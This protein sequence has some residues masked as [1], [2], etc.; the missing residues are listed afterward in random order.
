MNDR[1]D[2]WRARL[3]EY[4]DG[5]LASPE[6]A[7]LEEHLEECGDCR[8]LLDDLRRVITQ[9][10]RLVDSPPSEDLWAGIAERIHAEKPA[11]I[12]RGASTVTDRHRSR[13][14]SRKLSF[15]M[16]QLAAAAVLLVT[17]SSGVAWQ[18]AGGFSSRQ[19]E[20]AGPAPTAVASELLRVARVANLDYE[21]AIAQLETAL[22]AGR[23]SLDTATVR[24]VAER[25]A[26]IDRAIEEARQALAADPSNAYLNHYLAGTMR[27]KLDL[28]RRTA[29]LTEL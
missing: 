13:E 18:L 16:P 6:R 8:A 24:K 28:M 12:D 25:L 11:G 20:V 22:D 23:Q 29:A 7:A 14:A 27:R 2:I 17:V 10:S 3:S 9:A 21:S 19:E 26:L 15:S 1:T 4:L 5:E